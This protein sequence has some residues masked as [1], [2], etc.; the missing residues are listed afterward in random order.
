ME[1]DED[2]SSQE[3]GVEFLLMFC[4]S[5]VCLEHETSRWLVVSDLQRLLAVSKGLRSGLM[6]VDYVHAKGRTRERATPRVR[7]PLYPGL[8]PAGG[9][10]FRHQLAS[11]AAMRRA[12]ESTKSYGALRG[13]VLGDAPGLGKSVSVLALIL[14]TA[15]ELPRRPAEFWDEASVKETWKTL[16]KGKA[17]SVLREELLLGLKPLTLFRNAWRR[18]TF[19]WKASNEILTKASNGDFESPEALERYVSSE[20]TKNFGGTRSMTPAAREGLVADLSHALALVKAKLERRSRASLLSGAN[21]RLFEERLAKPSGATLLVVPDALMGHWRDMVLRHLW[22]DQLAPVFG[23]GAGHGIVY[24]QGIGDVQDYRARLGKKPPYRGA[25]PPDAQM[26]ED[27]PTMMSRTHSLPHADALRGYLLIVVPFSFCL[28]EARKDQLRQLALQRAKRR[29]AARTEVQESPLLKL[30]FLRLVVDEGHDL[31]AAATEQTAADRGA[32]PLLVTQF[33]TQLFVERR[34]VCSGT[35]TTGDVDDPGTTE[36]HLSQIQLLL[37]WLRHPVYG[38]DKDAR[39]DDSDTVK[40]ARRA[41]EKRFDTD[42]LQPFLQG[43]AQEENNNV[44]SSPEENNFTGRRV[45]PRLLVAPPEEDHSPEKARATLV[46]LLRRLF[47]RHRK[48]DLDLPKPIFRNVE[49]EVPRAEGVDEDAYQWLVDQALGKHIADTIVNAEKKRRSSTQSLPPVKM[50]VFSQHDNDLASVA[51][52]LYPR[53]GQNRVSEFYVNQLGQEIA[54][55]ELARFVKGERLVR[56][57]PVCGHENEMT[58]S[59]NN[60]C[61]RVLM[62]MEIYDDPNLVSYRQRRLAMENGLEARPEAAK[63]VLVEPERV[64]RVD[65]SASLCDSTAEYASN[66]RLWALGDLL[67]VDFRDSR[68][69]SLNQ[70]VAW[71]ASSCEAMAERDRYQSAFWYFAPLVPPSPNLQDDLLLAGTLSSVACRLVKWTRC[72][73][74]H[75]P[76]WFRGPSLATQPVRVEKEDVPILCLYRDASHGLD[77]SMLQHLFLL[78]PCRDSALL[79]Q[80]VSRAHR[81][82]ATQSVVCETLMP[83]VAHD[84]QKAVLPQENATPGGRRRRRL[85]ERQSTETPAK[86]FICDFCYRSFDSNDAADTHMTGCSRNPDNASLARRRFSIASVYDEIR[87]PLITA[88]QQEE[89]KGGD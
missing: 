89:E 29:T 72:S 61:D 66:H 25:A 49:V 32:M 24:M 68:R 67:R 52:T 86:I 18:G 48:E 55:F 64:V 39:L 9:G 19:E 6:S 1:E 31:A 57:C 36:R 51:E 28:V 40:D 56:T 63:R 23:D 35:P 69:P 74:A 46:E 65:R 14:S 8:F 53:L 37:T 7:W 85:S 5:R 12:E 50:A 42:I 45:R 22:F 20:L 4:R 73:Q 78:E 71:G 76:A 59:K 27:E 54:A 58:N 11:L 83:F 13:G 2:S 33:L 21:K 43:A 10:L 30:R 16:R 88:E 81:V 38:V 44:F 87:P 79:E 82:G 41:C 47:V 60:R 15:G 17:T 84:H 70:W 26:M 62:E 3:Q 75:G 77:L 34:W 80:V